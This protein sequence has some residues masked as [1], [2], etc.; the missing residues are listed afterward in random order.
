MTTRITTRTTPRP[1]RRLALLLISAT[2]LTGCG[3]HLRGEVELPPDLARVHIV[4]ADRDLVQRLS[5]ALK[6][7]GAAVVRAG[8]GATISL[9][10]EF[11]QTTLTTDPQGAASAY[12]VRYQVAFRIA[13]E[14]GQPLQA[15]RIFW[16]H[17]AFNY[18]SS[19]H[20]Q[21]EA[22][23]AFLQDELRDEAVVRIM[24]QLPRL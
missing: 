3:F 18:D 12:A 1:P 22:Q 15:E 7:R 13:A 2:L 11:A 6:Q 8:Q 9:A 14:D 23:E 16:L 20:L 5:A 24:R 19:K 17:R 4:G 21:A 10:S